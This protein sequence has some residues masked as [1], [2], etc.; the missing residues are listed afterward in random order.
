[1]TGVWMTSSTHPISFRWY[2]SVRVVQPPLI[3]I[4]EVCMSSPQAST[5]LSIEASRQKN[6]DRCGYLQVTPGVDTTTSG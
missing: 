1:M 3:F 4:E 2:G 6:A 5:L